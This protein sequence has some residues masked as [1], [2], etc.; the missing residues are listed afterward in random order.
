MLAYGASIVLYVSAAQRMGAARSQ[1]LFASAPFWGTLGAVLFLGERITPLQGAS[2]LLLAG[3]LALLFRDRHE[4]EH[5]HEPM[6][7]VHAH[8][9]L[10]GH[11]THAHPEHDPAAVHT[12]WHR[13]EPLVHAHPHWPD[14]H[15]RHEHSR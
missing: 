4:H 3:S 12:H 1:M 9:H 5:V 6:E 14:L 7:H 11:H 8:H 2:A 15:H 10:D 13:H